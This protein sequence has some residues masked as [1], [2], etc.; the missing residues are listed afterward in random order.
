[1]GPDMDNI[2]S[3]PRLPRPI[4]DRSL[5]AAVEAVR[6]LQTTNAVDIRVAAICVAEAF[7]WTLGQTAHFLTHLAYTEA[8]GRHELADA[9]LRMVYRSRLAGI[10][11]RIEEVVEGRRR[12]DFGAYRVELMPLV[13]RVPDD[14]LD[15]CPVWGPVV[16]SW[17]NVFLSEAVESPTWLEVAV[18]ANGALEETEGE[19]VTLEGVKDTGRV[20]G[21]GVPVYE[22]VMEAWDPD[23]SE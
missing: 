18:I 12:L 10:H 7:G 15:E 14:N 3:L 8:A 19:R 17:G 6:R 9:D 1:M 23:S 2:D 21:D 16:F 4:H 11:A 20:N 22:L 13:G 5:A